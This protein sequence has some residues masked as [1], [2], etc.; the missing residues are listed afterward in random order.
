MLPP[1]TEEPPSQSAPATMWDIPVKLD[2]NR[3]CPNCYCRKKATLHVS[4]TQH[5]PGR[6]FWTCPKRRGEQCR[7][8]SWVDGKHQISPAAI[9]LPAEALHLTVENQMEELQR[10]MQN[11]C[12]H[13]NVSRTG[14][15][16]FVH[17][18]TCK[19]CKKVLRDEK[20]PRATASK[21]AA[22]PSP[23]TPSYPA[24]EDLD[25]QEYLAWKARRRME[26]RHSR[27]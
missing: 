21:A 4:H 23:T 5:N 10:Q 14:S 1:T 19:D 3:E 18:E 11:V 12:P 15:N 25:Y 7:Y 9:P 16:A 26:A 22:S 2:Y 24:G 27:P 20:V 13:R 17:K 8:F 6:L